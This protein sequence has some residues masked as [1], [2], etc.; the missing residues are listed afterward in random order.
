MN[1]RLYRFAIKTTDPIRRELELD[2][3]MS[4][5]MRPAVP[6]L[7]VFGEPVYCPTLTDDQRTRFKELLGIR[8]DI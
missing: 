2:Y 3:A 8:E 5:G 6:D 4:H 1:D 7:W